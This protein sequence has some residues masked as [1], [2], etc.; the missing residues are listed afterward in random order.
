[1]LDNKVDLDLKM[2]LLTSSFKDAHEGKNFDAF[3]SF[4]DQNKLKSKF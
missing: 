2:N 1:M 3:E 4:G